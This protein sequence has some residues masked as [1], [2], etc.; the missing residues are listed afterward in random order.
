MKQNK[1][2]KAMAMCNK[3][4]PNKNKQKTTNK[5]EK[6]ML[7]DPIYIKLKSRQN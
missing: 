2:N 5:K 3:Q 6:Y 1:K 7:Y 4:K